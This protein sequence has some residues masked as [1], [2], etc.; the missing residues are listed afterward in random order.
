MFP[1]QGSRSRVNKM[2]KAVTT[3]AYS[4][5]TLHALMQLRHRRE[6]LERWLSSEVLPAGIANTLRTMLAE[7]D[8]QL[9]T[10]NDRSP[11]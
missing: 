10:L 3:P 11:N 1:I 4:A 8:E 5:E 6:I 7:V 2:S 9:G